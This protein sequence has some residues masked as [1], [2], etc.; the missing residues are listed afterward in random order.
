M[1]EGTRVELVLPRAEAVAEEAAVAAPRAV[2]E[3]RAARILV[4]D[5]DDEVRHV[6]A[7][8]LNGFGYRETEAKDGSAALALLKTGEFDLVVADLAMPGMTGIDL[9]EAIRR[10]GLSIP[11]LI[12][13]GHAEAV[14]IPPDI[15]VLRKPFDSAELA[16]QVAGLLS[17][18]R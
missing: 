8:F 3:T 17:S 10:S 2:L 4:V 1:G 7:S 13:T 9:M 15:A 11:I 12:V 6:T 16:A 18:G 5:D 14:P